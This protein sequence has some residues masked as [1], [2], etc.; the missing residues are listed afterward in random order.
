MNIQEWAHHAES[1]LGYLKVYDSGP[2]EDP[3]PV[4]SWF[5]NGS[6]PNAPR[7]K[8]RQMKI[9]DGKVWFRNEQKAGQYSQWSWLGDIERTRSIFTRLLNAAVL[10]AQAYN[11]VAP[12]IDLNHPEVRCS[13]CGSLG[14]YFC[15][16]CRAEQRGEF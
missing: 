7:G 9:E 12:R 13:G 1:V 5:R 8:V 2:K 11:R 15:G 10:D 3:S 16:G 6:G 14:A 4:F